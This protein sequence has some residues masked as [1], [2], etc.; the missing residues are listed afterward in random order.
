MFAPEPQQHSE[1]R[2]AAGMRRVFRNEQK[3]EYNLKIP[4][5]FLNFFFA[6]LDC[7]R[8]GLVKKKI[9][10][11]QVNFISTQSAFVQWSLKRKREQ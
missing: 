2:A 1:D 3:I 9:K 4:F 7:Y 6:Q 8:L 5:F 10:A 11:I